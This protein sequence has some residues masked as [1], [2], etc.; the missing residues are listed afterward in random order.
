M[1]YSQLSPNHKYIVGLIAK[2]FPEVLSTN[3]VNRKQLVQVMEKFNIKSAAWLTNPG[4]TISRGIY[5]FPEFD[6]NNISSEDSNEESENIVI[7]NSE[8][9]DEEIDIDIRERFL[10]MNE[11]VISVAEQKHR[12]LIISSPPGIG[13]TEGVM[14]ILDKHG[15]EY[16]FVSGS[17]SAVGI[18]EMLYANRAPNQIV[19]FDDCDRPF[20]DE[21]SLNVLKKACDT[22]KV[23][24]I[25]WLK[26]SS[27][28]DEE[29]EPIPKQF[30]YEGSCI[31]ITNKD[32]YEMSKSGNKNCEHIEA[33]ITRS[34]YVHLGIRTAREYLIRINQV[35]E[36]GMLRKEG[37]S[38][39]EENEIM[40]FIY[41]H[42][43]KL[44][45]LSL[46]MVL[47]IASIYKNNYDNWKTLAK[48]AC[49]KV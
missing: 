30:Y 36:E 15:F 38:K 14:R 4:N 25:S 26:K 22:K 32:L 21:E 2:E 18:Y 29:G 31:F 12:S 49:F 17:A 7:N 34:L 43:D 3:K 11:F 8:K 40:G 16:N 10:A 45:D 46:R 33:I 24:T 37:I 41:E 28:F 27:L 13:K 48:V 9:S 5:K 6:I 35:L 39:Q 42:K 19:I 47:K 44:I 23:R 20:F 1:K